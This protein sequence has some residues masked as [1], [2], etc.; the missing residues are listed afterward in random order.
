MTSPGAAAG[1][2]HPPVWVGAL[3]DINCLALIYDLLKK[4]ARRLL[5]NK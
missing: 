4:R 1:M 3:I 5:M 2:R